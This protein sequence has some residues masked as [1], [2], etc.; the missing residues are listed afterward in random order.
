MELS[1]QD[2]DKSANEFGKD[3]AKNEDKLRISLNQRHSKQ[4]CSRQYSARSSTAL[5]KLTE[6]DPGEGRCEKVVVQQG[7]SRCWIQIAL[8][9]IQFS[10]LMLRVDARLHVFLE[11]TT[12][13]GTI[14]SN[15]KRIAQ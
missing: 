6:L 1:D 7:D 12:R 3:N 9:R 13:L 15:K 2:I 14:Y 8:R 4:N 10:D 11:R 5:I